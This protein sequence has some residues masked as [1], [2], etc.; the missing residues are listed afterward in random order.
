MATVGYGVLQ[1]MPSMRG[2]DTAIRRQLGTSAVRNAA[3]AAG[4]TVGQDFASGLDKAGKSVRDTGTK[5]STWVTAPIAAIGIGII[6]TAGDFQSS[7]NRIKAVSGAT[8][9]EFTQLRDQAKELGATTQFSASQ[10]ADAMGFLAMAGFKASDIMTALPGVLNLAAAGAID[11]GEAADIASNI[12]S[13]YGF[14]AKDIGKVNDVLAKTF[15]STNVDMR[16]LGESFKYVGPVAK[17]AGLGFEEVSAAVGLL[18]NA[19]IQGSQ[20]GTTLRMAIARLA[21]PPKMAQKALKALGL[22]VNDSHGKMLPLVDILRQLEKTGANTAQMMSIFGIEAGPGMQALVSQGS[23]ALEKLTGDLENSGGTAERIAKVQMEGLN[24][25]FLGLK[26]AAEGLALEIADAGILDWVTGLTQRLTGLVSRLNQTNPA[27]L[28]IGSIVAL[29]VAAVGPLLVVLGLAISGVGTALGFL[30]TPVGAVVAGVVLL[31]AALGT[32]YATSKP[33]RDFVNDLARTLMSGLVDAFRAVQEVVQAR[34]VPALVGLWQAFS[35]RVLPVLS[36][37]AATWLPKLLAVFKT[38]ALVITGTVLPVLVSVGSWLLAYVVPPL[39]TVAKVAGGLLLDALGGLVTSGAAVLTWLTGMGAWLAPVAVAAAGLTLAITAQRIATA[40]V[41]GV[42]RIYRA[43]IL[44]WTAVQRGATIAQLAFNAVMNANPVIL[45]ITAI[46]ALG[47][48]LVVAYKKSETFRAIVQG[49]LAGIQAAAMFVW[50]KGIKPALAGIVAAMQAVAAAATWL[51]QTVLSP[52]FSFI[53]QAAKILGIILA[54]V[55]FGPIILLVKAV[56]A[57]VTWLWSAAFKPAFQA[58]GAL[59]TWLYKTALK[60][61]LDGVAAAAKWLWNTVLKP[62]FE[63]AKLG[64]RALGAV[65]QWLYAN[66]VKPVMSWIGT[67]LAVW[68]ASAKIVFSAVVSFVKSVLGPVFRW[69]YDSVIKPVWSAIK[70]T[71]ST[72]WNNGIKPAFNALKTAIGK[73]GDAFRTAKDAIAKAWSAIKDATKS[74]INWVLRVVWNEGIVPTWDRITGWIPG[75]PKLGKLKMLKA[76]GTVGDGFGQAATPGMYNKPTAIVGEGNPAHPE[77]VIPTD[78]KFRGRALDL[79]RAAGGQLLADGGVIGGLK[80]VGKKVVGGITGAAGFLADPVGSA[81]KLLGPLLDKAK[82]H[83]GDTTFAK[84]AI[85]LPKM[86]ISGLKDVVKNAAGSLFGGGGG[87]AVGAG[88]QRW[89]PLV[90]QVLSM[91]GAPSSA[92]GAVLTRMNMESG[93]NPKAINLWDSNAKA[94][95][96]SKGL[97]QVI[98]P[99]FSTYAGPMRGRGIW[100][101]LANVYAGL[102]YAMHRYG[103]WQQVMTRPGGYDSGGMLPTGLSTVYNGTGRPERVLTDRQWDAITAT[104]GDGAQPVSY[105]I[106]ARTADFTVADLE[107]LQRVQDARARVGRPR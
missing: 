54:I 18:G 65:F 96:P 83:L 10:A 73:V 1:I 9:S 11:L 57:V 49:A 79:W 77:F 37:L 35:A 82:S 4:R 20:A 93:G 55:V 104:S 78:P 58:I 63:A 89:A 81:A 70:S 33:F 69:L 62:T 39:L 74:P 68:W 72:V 23:D 85:G 80:K 86:M 64:I 21:K 31:G 17:S 19:G 103:N 3:G 92:L 59:A 76:G 26:S 14:Q 40:L 50:E 88:V 5:L 84:M 43:A 75:V 32:A 16:M 47:V 27:V 51:W 52:A 48:A 12:L 94:G 25:A 61:A 44:A 106:N 46:V 28:K 42:F 29:V 60:P 56:A 8:G 90:S 22:E 41:T 71:I 66:A 95:I 7:M 38:L 102:N 24:G 91:L 100:D 87:G 107:L 30:L 99:T 34:L 6:K 13:G 53:G 101:P 2:I 45:V 67:A 97:M 15:T 36:S 98:D 105:T